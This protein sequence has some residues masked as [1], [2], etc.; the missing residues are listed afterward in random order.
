MAKK[1]PSRARTAGYIQPME[2]LSVPKVPEGAEWT[3]ELKLDG[4]RLEV[5]RAGMVT[6]LYSRRENVLNE[7]FPYIASALKR[8]PQGTVIDGELVAMG[9]DGKPNFNLLQNFRS[10]EEHIIYY[11]FDILVHKDHDLT[12]RPLAERREILRSVITRQITSLFPR[13]PIRQRP[14]C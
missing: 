7:K 2:C 6:T 3:Y 9:P 8:L 10:A 14:K 4:Y 12:M 5:V 1:P 11:A 13:S